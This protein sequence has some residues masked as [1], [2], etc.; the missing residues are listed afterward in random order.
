MLTENV[1]IWTKT[2]DFKDFNILNISLAFESVEAL[3]VNIIKI[4]QKSM[5]SPKSLVF[6][7][8][9]DHKSFVKLYWKPRENSFSL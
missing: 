9:Q 5:N 8:S 4:Q 1:F 2:L 7:D 6:L 3:S